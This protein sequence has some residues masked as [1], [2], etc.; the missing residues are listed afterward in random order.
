[1][2]YAMKYALFSVSSWSFFMQRASS[3]RMALNTT[4]SAAGRAAVG[5]NRMPHPRQDSACVRTRAAHHREAAH[6]VLK[7]QAIFEVGLLDLFNQP[8]LQLLAA[9]RL[10]R[11]NNQVGLAC[12]HQASRFLA[13]M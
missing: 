2:R 9:H 6:D 12:R 3:S 7:Q 5:V 11:L 4:S 10:R 13:A 8:F 1:M